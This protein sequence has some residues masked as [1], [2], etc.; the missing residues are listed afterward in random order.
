MRLNVAMLLFSAVVQSFLCVTTTD[1][2]MTEPSDWL[3]CPSTRQMFSA[4]TGCNIAHSHKSLAW[5]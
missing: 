4:Y 5:P 2:L 1:E 3:M